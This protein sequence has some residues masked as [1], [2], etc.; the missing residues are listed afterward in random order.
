MSYHLKEGKQAGG[1]IG[2]GSE[3]FINLRC[4]ATHARKG[5]GIHSDWTQM[6]EPIIELLAFT[7]GTPVAGKE[8]INVPLPIGK[9]ET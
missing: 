1:S 6:M 5:F 7:H 4:A 8:N 2:F 9:G 3:T